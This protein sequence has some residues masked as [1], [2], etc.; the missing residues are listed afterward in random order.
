M[1]FFKFHFRNEPRLPD[2][3][4]RTDEARNIALEH[5]EAGRSVSHSMDPE[6]RDQQQRLIDKVLTL[7]SCLFLSQGLVLE[8]ITTVLKLP[9]NSSE[10]CVLNTFVSKLLRILNV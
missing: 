2:P 6:A 5:R 10:F 4:G 8:L 3:P 9:V 7:S 1:K